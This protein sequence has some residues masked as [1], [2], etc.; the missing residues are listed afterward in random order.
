MVSWLLRAGATDIWSREAVVRAVSLELRCQVSCTLSGGAFAVTHLAG[1]CGVH[2][3]DLASPGGMVTPATALPPITTVATAA[4]LAPPS[5]VKSQ[6]LVVTPFSDSGTNC[7]LVLAQGGE[8]PT[9][10]LA[11]TAGL[12]G[13]VDCRLLDSMGDRDDHSLTGCVQGAVNEKVP[14]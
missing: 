6:E 3:V 12:D 5:S 10:A 8:E 11:L 9:K 14:A 13:L 1:P 7:M 4:A 2:P